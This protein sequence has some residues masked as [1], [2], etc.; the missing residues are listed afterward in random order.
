MGF[1]FA[2]PGELKGKRGRG[3]ERS[4]MMGSS[5]GRPSRSGK[6]GARELTKEDSRVE[7]RPEVER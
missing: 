6:L 7:S 2:L 1:G 5:A 4:T 3:A